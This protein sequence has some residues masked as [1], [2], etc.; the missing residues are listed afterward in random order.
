MRKHIRGTIQSNV[1]T[2][3]ASRTFCYNGSSKEVL[4]SVSPSGREKLVSWMMN[5]A[6]A[7]WTEIITSKLTVFFLSLQRILT[8]SQHTRR[9]DYYRLQSWC[10]RWVVLGQ[11]KGPLFY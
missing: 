10:H 8:S 11:G 2:F 9:K 7:T 5:L 6:G 3:Y 1:S 4:I